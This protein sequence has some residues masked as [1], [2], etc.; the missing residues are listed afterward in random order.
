MPPTQANRI[1]YLTPP[2]TADSLLLSSF[3]G[4]EAMSRLFSY[5]LQ[6]VSDN[7][8]I[9]ASDIVGKSVTWTVTYKTNP[10]RY[11][12]GFVSR[13]AGADVTARQMRNYR[14]QVVPWLWFLTRTSDCQIFQ[15]KAVPDIIE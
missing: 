7:L 4:T 14:V 15:K 8:A 11:F 5:Q 10:P 3:S 6:M 13:F 9:Q 12:N 1:L 2:S